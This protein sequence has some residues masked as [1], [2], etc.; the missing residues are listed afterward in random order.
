MVLTVSC[1]KQQLPGLYESYEKNDKKP[2][3]GFSSWQALRGAYPL[4]TFVGGAWRTTHISQVEEEPVLL[5]LLTRQLLLSDV[6]VEDFMNFVEAGNDVFISA[7]LIDPKLLAKFNCHANLLRETISEAT[8]R[9]AKT[10]I[11]TSQKDRPYSYFYYPFENFFDHYDKRRSTV[12]GVNASGE[13]NFIRYDGAGGRVFLHLAP[14]ALSNYFVLSRENHEYLEWVVKTISPGEK[15]IYWDEY[16]KRGEH[17]KDQNHDD[18]K[19]AFSALRVIRREP[20]LLWAFWLGI[21]AI[22]FYIFTYV[23]RRQRQV[24]AV[25][26]PQNTT[27]EFTETIAALYLQKKNNKRMAEKMIAYF[28]ETISNKYYIGA[29]MNRAAALKAAASRL[30]VSKAQVDGL[31]ERLRDVEESADVS[32]EQFKLLNDTIDSFLYGH[33]KPI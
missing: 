3:G 1:R 9:M 29:G 5:F 7:D 20:P 16:Y 32:D 12:L 33:G 25:E 19:S 31:L 10:V 11:W 4:K 23:K 28:F 22:V 21:A 18:D 17:L 30:G 14:R 26:K 15:L 24:P 2:F 13:P 6:D 8:E 27:L